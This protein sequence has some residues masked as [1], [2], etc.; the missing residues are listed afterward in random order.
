[1]KKMIAVLTLTAAMLTGLLAQPAPEMKKGHG[2]D[3]AG[4]DCPQMGS[5]HKGM[6][7][8]GECG[9]KGMDHGK[10]QF[11]PMMVQEL[12]LSKDQLDKIHKIKVKFDR[13]GVDL[14]AEVD[15]LRID[16][17]E[18]MKEMKYDEA[19]K[20]AQKMSDASLKIKFS[21]IDEMKE[22][23]EVL[24]PEQKAKFKDMHG[25]GHGMMKH[26]MMKKDK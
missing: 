9:M 24:T 11:G 2:P 18:A 16:K 14:K 8:G 17:R 13:A 10:D 26:K 12:D 23:T 21:K 4:N 19:K 25:S 3:L 20:V 7:K 6:G 1:M 5:M 15:K 22:L